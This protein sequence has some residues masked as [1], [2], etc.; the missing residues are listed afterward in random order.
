MNQKLSD[1]AS[2]A[3]IVS[4]VAVVA[5]L[6][7]L[8]F[9]IR[10]NT[11]VTRAAAYEGLISSLN[12]TTQMLVEDESLAT[13]WQSYQAGDSAELNQEERFRLRL[14]L[15]MVW[16]TYEAA[17]YSNEYGTLGESEW[18]RFYRRQ[19][20]TLSRTEPADWDFVR[21]V[22]T[23]EFADYVDGRCRNDVANH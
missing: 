21:A 12:G 6:V 17:Y 1:W 5:T 23:R 18:E 2:V 20:A 13:I 16:R 3:E 9:G 14:V 10:E 7:F 4:G 22:L 8:I 11:E 15:T 19:C